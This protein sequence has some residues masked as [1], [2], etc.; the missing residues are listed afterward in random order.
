MSRIDW[1]PQKVEAARR[2]NFWCL[3]MLPVAAAV[4]M[5]MMEAGLGHGE[6]VAISICGVLARWLDDPEFVEGLRCDA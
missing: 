3:A 6:T 5:A 1:T 2:A 4:G